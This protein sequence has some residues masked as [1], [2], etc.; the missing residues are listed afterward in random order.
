[1]Q[2]IL[3]SVLFMYQ[4]VR[5]L[6]LPLLNNLMQERLIRCLWWVYNFQLCLH[7]NRIMFMRLRW[8]S[9]LFSVALVMIMPLTEWLTHYWPGCSI[10]PS[11]SA[12]TDPSSYL[13]LIPRISE[14]M[15]GMKLPQPNYPL[16]PSVLSFSLTT[17]SSTT[18]SMMRP[19]RLISYPRF[20]STMSS[21]SLW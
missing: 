16:K 10:P 12:S 4:L 14:R 7:H 18:S 3:L 11:P 19:R 15:S 9:I 8:L 2:R 21:P 13:S 5:F 1:M 6:S 20:S 17:P